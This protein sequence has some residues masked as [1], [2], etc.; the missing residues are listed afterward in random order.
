VDADERLTVFAADLLADQ[1]WSEA[2]AGVDYVMHVASPMGVGEYKSQDL[3]PP[4]REGTRRALEA[5][6]RGGA[7]HVVLTSSLEAAI[8]PKVRSEAA[9]AP[10]DESVWTD[11]RS[12]TVSNYRR[13]KTLAEQDAWAFIKGGGDTAMTLTTILPAF[14]QGP[15]MG[16]DYSGSVDTVARMLK[17]QVP[18]V[19]RLCFAIVDIRD[20][21]DLHMRAM[22]DPR[23]V[24][25]R[26]IATSESLWMLQ[27]ADVLREHL[28][29]R[30]AKLPKA[31]APD[32]M[33]RLAAVANPELR[34]ILPGLGVRREF[35]SAKAEQLLGW[36]ARPARN[37]IID[38]ADSLIAAGLV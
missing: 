12:R 22:T 1:G 30:A 24:G 32:A 2:A 27:I 4:A 14:I 19:P 25:E 16:A 5:A 31:E 21:V 13:A 37:S 28:G 38:A 18:A 3:V 9:G 15:V 23:A 10:T 17:G 29:D 8:P 20:L 36:R 11:T 35:T 34:Q 26:F 6:R 33:I 7:R